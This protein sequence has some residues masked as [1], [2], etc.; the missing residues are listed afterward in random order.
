MFIL[1]KLISISKTQE[2][3]CDWSVIVIGAGI[4]GLSAA[5]TLEKRGCTVIV[6][7]ANDRI[8][9]RIKSVPLGLNSTTIDM[10]ASWIHGIGPGAGELKSWKGKYN[11]V[12][13]F[14]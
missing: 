6:L 7:E 11:P 1:I 3:A 10:E 5:H 4:S 13:E 2:E 14:V 8:G 12:W 9:G